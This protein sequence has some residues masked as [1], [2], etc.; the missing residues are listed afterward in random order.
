MYTQR[1]T[2]GSRPQPGRAPFRQNRPQRPAPPP[3]VRKG[4]IGPSRPAAKAPAS[5]KERRRMRKATTH[6]LARM[7]HTQC[8]KL[9]ALNGDEMFLLIRTTLGEGYRTGAGEARRLARKLLR[10]RTSAA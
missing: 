5:G 2:Y 3:R 6:R 10:L 8:S 1:N 9:V 4:P 7:L